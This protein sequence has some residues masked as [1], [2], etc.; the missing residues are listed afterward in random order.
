MFLAPAELLILPELQLS[1]KIVIFTGENIEC[2]RCE[3]EV[4]SKL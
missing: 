4:D 1:L 2:V 3:G